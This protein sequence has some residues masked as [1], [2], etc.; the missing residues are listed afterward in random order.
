MKTTHDLFSVLIVDDDE[1]LC[2]LLKASLPARFSV[3]VEHSLTEAEKY[4]TQHQPSLLFLDNSLPDG[5]GLSF[6][7]EAIKLY[8]KIKIVMMTADAGSG[9][10]DQAMRQGA[11]YFIPKPFR[12]SLVKEIVF[13]IFPNLSAA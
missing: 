6:I 12:L 5:T 11:C 13:S 4:L 1:D 3:H 7:K 2:N 9:I 8:R 10:K